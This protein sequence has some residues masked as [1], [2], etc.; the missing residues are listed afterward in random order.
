LAVLGHPREGLWAA[1][2]AATQ[3]PDRLP[4][5]GSSSHVPAL[6]GMTEVELAAADVWATGISPDSYPTQFLR[7]DLDA[8]GVLPADQLLG[9]PDG[10]RVL[11]AGAVTHRNARPPAQGVTFIEHRGRDRAWSTCSARRGVEPAPQ[12]GADGVGLLIRGQVQNATGA[13][14]VIAER[15]AGSR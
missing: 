2:A 12:A 10:S 11:I 8:M 4:G 7:D 15:M 1:G 3:R 13:V 9:V 5:V 14:T 6:P